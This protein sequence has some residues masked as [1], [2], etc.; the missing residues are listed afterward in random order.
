ML[1]I[2]FASKI[3]NPRT[4]QMR[5]GSARLV[6]SMLALMERSQHQVILVMTGKPGYTITVLRTAY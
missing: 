6:L 1:G 5:S 4:R 3:N 2:D